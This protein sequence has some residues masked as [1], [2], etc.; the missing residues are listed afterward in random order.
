MKNDGGAH[1]RRF[2]CPMFN[3]AGFP[4][5]MCPGGNGSCSAAQ[6]AHDVSRRYASSR[7]GAVLLFFAS[8]LDTD[9]DA[10]F[11]LPP[12]AIH[13]WVAGSFQFAMCLCCFSVFSVLRFVL[14]RV[15][16]AGFNLC[17]Q[18]GLVR[19]VASLVSLLSAAPS[20]RS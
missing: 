6:S 12:G 8:A 2:D 3:P 4:P 13:C 17:C 9:D 20:I 1:R 15:A 7:L 16:S 19:S 11:A 5:F 14:S 10:V 18:K